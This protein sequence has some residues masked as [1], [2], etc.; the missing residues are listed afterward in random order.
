MLEK[1]LINP[2]LYICGLLRNHSAVLSDQLCMTSDYPSNNLQP[3]DRDDGC[4]KVREYSGARP[5]SDWTPPPVMVH[6]QPGA[7]T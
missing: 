7:G 2:T 1:C 3:A 6:S 5:S 4:G